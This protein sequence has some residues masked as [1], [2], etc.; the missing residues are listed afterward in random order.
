M[1]IVQIFGGLGNQMFRY[2]VGRRLAA[3]KDVAL[4]LD[5]SAFEFYTLRTYK[6]DQFDILAEIAT[7]AELER[8]IAPGKWGKV[9]RLPNG[10]CC[11]VCCARSTT[12]GCS[13]SLMLTV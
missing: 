10:A 3:E 5:I 8:F 11:R 12:N 2:A 13:T 9:Q 1:I 6:L 4:K 7:S